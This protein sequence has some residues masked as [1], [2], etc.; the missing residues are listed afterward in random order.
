MSREMPMLMLMPMDMSW[1]RED[2]RRKPSLGMEWHWNVMLF[3]T[4]W[5]DQKLN[6]HRNK[7]LLL[8]LI[9]HHQSRLDHDINVW[10]RIAKEQ[11]TQRNISFDSSFYET[12]T[13]IYYVKFGNKHLKVAF[14]LLPSIKIRC[15][16]CWFAA[17]TYTLGTFAIRLMFS[18]F[19]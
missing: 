6:F 4:E 7:L 5:S 3:E 19:V 18:F 8:L 11:H 15:S 12:H 10:F 9:F 14:D 13:R 1:L 17:Y 16:C 2:K